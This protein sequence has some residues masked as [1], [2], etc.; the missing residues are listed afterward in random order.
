VLVFVH[1]TRRPEVERKSPIMP[2]KEAK[3]RALAG[4]VP[5][6][7][8]TSERFESNYQVE[9]R[10]RKGKRNFLA[11]LGRVSLI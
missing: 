1:G 3:A 2:A 9:M 10:G 5:G 4:G 6:E 8:I 11:I 7:S